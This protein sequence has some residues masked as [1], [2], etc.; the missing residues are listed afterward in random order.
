MLHGRLH[1]FLTI[2]NSDFKM[3]TFD[4]NVNE[5]VANPGKPIATSILISSKKRLNN[6]LIKLK[7]LNNYQIFQQQKKITFALEAGMLTA[8][9]S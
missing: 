1:I 4:T 8:V 7:K 2:S 9:P 6:K 5:K 3:S